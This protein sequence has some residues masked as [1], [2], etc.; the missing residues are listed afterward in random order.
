M[1]K[2]LLRYVWLCG[3]SGIVTEFSVGRANVVDVNAVPSAGDGTL[4]HAGIY[5]SFTFCRSAG[6]NWTCLMVAAKG[7]PRMV[8]QLLRWGGGVIC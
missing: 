6:R 5:S 8:S 4:C 7:K 2:G 1:V 3:L